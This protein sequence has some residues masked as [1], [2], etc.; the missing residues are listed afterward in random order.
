MKNLNF[1]KNNYEKQ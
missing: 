1:N